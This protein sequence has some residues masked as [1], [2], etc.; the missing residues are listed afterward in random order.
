M[1][2]QVLIVHLYIFACVLNIGVSRLEVDS[3]KRV[4]SMYFNITTKVLITY[5]LTR[6]L[7]LRYIVILVIKFKK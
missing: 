6:V 1:F 3:S 2:I 7:R 5:Y 4:T